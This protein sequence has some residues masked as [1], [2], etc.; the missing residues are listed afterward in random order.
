VFLRDVFEFPSSHLKSLFDRDWNC[1]VGF[2]HVAV[3]YSYL[4]ISVLACLMG[5]KSVVETIFHESATVKKFL[6]SANRRHFKSEVHAACNKLTV[7]VSFNI[8][9][10]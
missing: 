1:N 9:A 5:R 6:H 4:I 2:N 8:L 3:E 7:P 10:L